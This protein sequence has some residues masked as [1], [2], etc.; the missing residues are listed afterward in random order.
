MRT[1]HHDVTFTKAFA[2][3]GIDAV[4]QPGTYRVSIEEEEFATTNHQG[5]RR[6][7]TTISVRSAHG[8]IEQHVINPIDLEV[9][10]LRDLGGT[11]GA[12]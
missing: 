1:T 7:A 6:V 9:A 10:L 5:F 4:Q 2:L 12:A 11:F 8:A 3:P